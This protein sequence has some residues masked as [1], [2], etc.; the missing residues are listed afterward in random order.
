MTNADTT[1]PMILHRQSGG[2]VAEAIPV[3]VATAWSRLFMA[4]G[5]QPTAPAERPATVIRSGTR[6]GA[7]KARVLGGTALDFGREKAL[8]GLLVRAARAEQARGRK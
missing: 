2:Q 7:A 5:F 4:A 1:Q 8:G 3:N 6:M